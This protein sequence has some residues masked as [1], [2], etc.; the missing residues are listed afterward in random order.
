MALKK[1]KWALKGHSTI[2]CLFRL[3]DKKLRPSFLSP[4]ARMEA[5]EKPE[6][7]ITLFW[8]LMEKMRKKTSHRW[9]N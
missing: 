4:P 8:Y 6:G 5:E 2:L 1:S 3:Y 9:A 7:S